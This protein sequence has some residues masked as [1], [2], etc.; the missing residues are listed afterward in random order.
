MKATHRTKMNFC[1][2]EMIISTPIFQP[3]GHSV[4]TGFGAHAVK[5]ENKRRDNKQEA[6]N[7][8]RGN[9]E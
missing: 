1:G 2:K 7:V 6:R 9:W 8:K 5:K 4:S 3:K